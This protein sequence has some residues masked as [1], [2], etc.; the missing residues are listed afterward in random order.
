MKT[1]SQQGSR[2]AEEVFPQDAM[3][4]FDALAKASG[5]G[6]PQGALGAKVSSKLFEFF[7]NRSLRWL[8]V[9]F[10]VGFYLGCVVS[11]AKNRAQRQT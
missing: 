7:R 11:E 6:F 3:D 10:L 1:Q 2:V 9:E 4:V 8:S 5:E